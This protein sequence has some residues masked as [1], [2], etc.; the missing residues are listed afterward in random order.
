MSIIIDSFENRVSS[1]IDNNKDVKGFPNISEYGIT[2]EELNDYLFDK[3]MIIDNMHDE[4]KTYTIFGILAVMPA[5]VASAFTNDEKYLIPSIGIG[6]V[7]GIAYYIVNK[8]TLK[9]KMRKLHDD[10]IENYIND[11]MNF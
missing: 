11:V 7:L 8:M 5:V 1:K 3:Q 6:V 4:K 10:K 9:L 2:R